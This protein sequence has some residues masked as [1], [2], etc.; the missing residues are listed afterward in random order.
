MCY[1]KTITGADPAENL[2]VA[3]FF[4]NQILGWSRAIVPLEN[5]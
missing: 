2:T 1:F 4:P 5:V 3:A